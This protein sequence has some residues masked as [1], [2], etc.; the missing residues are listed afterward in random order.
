MI[1]KRY[2]VENFRSVLDSGWI[3]C[4]NVTTLV[5]INEAG[6]SNLLLALWKLNPAREGN[7]DP[8]HDMPVSKLST[9]R[10]TP[11][12]IKFITA[13]FELEDEA[14]KNIEAEVECDLQ[15]DKLVTVTRYYDGN[16]T[17]EFPS[18]SPLSTKIEKVK[19]EVEEVEEPTEEDIIV[20][21]EA[22]NLEKA[23]LAELPSFVYYSNYGNLSS[24]IYLPNVIKWLNGQ[25][26][27]GIDV[28]EEQVR[29][30]RVLFD[31]VKLD[32]KE[33]L[34]LGK[35]PKEMAI[36][37]NGGHANIQPTSADIK[38]AENDKEER[39]ILLQSASGDL[40]KRFKEWW[41]QGE[42]KFRFEADGDYFRIWVSD[43]IRTDEVALELRSTGLQWF[44]SF[45]LIFLVESKE[46]HKGAIL[47][48]DEAGLTL[49]PLAQKDLAV[50]F[51]NLSQGN[52][53]INTTHSPFIVD[54][55][56][57]DRCRVVYMDREGYTVA[58]S[59]LRQGS[60]ALNE[61]SI[62]A[63]HAALGLSVS[64]VLLQGCQAIVVEGPSDQFY[65]NAI[66]GFLIRE[67]LIAPEQ[68]IVFVPS[69][70]VK[71]VPGV[72]SMISSKA[73]DI[74]Y[75]IIDSDKSGEDAKKRLLSGLYK[76][77]ENRILDIKDY[78]EIEKSEVEDLI[79]FTLIKKGVNRLFNSLDEI[80]F[81]D[82]YNKE[83][84]VVSQ[85]EA[86]AEANGIE[87]EKGWKV[88]VSMA[89]KSQ[90]KNKKADAI[91]QEYVDKWA[92]LF[93]A[94]LSA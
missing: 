35:D 54:T 51:D 30:L 31:F 28:N 6:K 64:D 77:F 69:G 53:I 84:T 58:S 19:K 41:K 5:G 14:I 49:H 63:V 4:D 70:G 72:V 82:T 91:P 94:F 11:E 61:K 8:L 10:K 66:K 59:N 85:I 74:P 56:N 65:L 93:N 55:S 90:L 38:K 81:E 79:P 25:A 12:D 88:G 39:S 32:P 78:T 86:F 60:D 29:T 2:K 89:A 7:I 21:Y 73:G 75:L 17:F 52:Q 36:A 22:E 43:S 67:K 76:G 1:L 46:R 13:E 33:I 42:Y 68:E 18:G 50:F 24:K 9:Y 87:L 20:P 83:F 48:L 71:G 45:Y 40:T 16:Y 15:G 44:I 62:Y 80:D 37:R 3:D 34:E 23:I 57:I 92:K 26:V 47:L 27:D